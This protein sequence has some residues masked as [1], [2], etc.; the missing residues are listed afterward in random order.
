ML[1]KNQVI[2][3]ANRLSIY[4]FI[5]A[6]FLHGKLEKHWIKG[7]YYLKVSLYRWAYYLIA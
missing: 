6:G 4:S 1:I 7:I 3:L 2:I 5:K